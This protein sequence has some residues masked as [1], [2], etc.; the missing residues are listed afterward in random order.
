MDII[1]GQVDP[2]YLKQGIYRATNWATTAVAYFGPLWVATA[3]T[4]LPDS[5]GG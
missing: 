5:I 4:A 3:R 1:N 2:T